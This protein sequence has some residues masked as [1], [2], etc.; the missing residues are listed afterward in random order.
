MTLSTIGGHLAKF[1]ASGDLEI[2]RIV[3]QEK[4][5]LV[6][7]F[8]EKAETSAFSETMAVLGDKITYAEL[9]MIHGYLYSGNMEPGI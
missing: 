4:I 7:A 6:K 5:D 1:V 9:R 8:Y 2:S 3:T